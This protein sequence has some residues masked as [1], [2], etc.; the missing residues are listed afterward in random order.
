MRQYYE[1]NPK[2]IENKH[3]L[4]LH[5]GLHAATCE[6]LG[7]IWQNIKLNKT[8][9]IFNWDR[10]KFRATKWKVAA[11]DLAPALIDDMSG[12]DQDSVKL[13][14][15]RTR[16]YAWGWINRNREALLLRANEI[17]AATDGRGV[18]LNKEG[19]LIWK[20]RRDK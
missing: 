16:G 9:G 4:A 5:E 3:L 1:A 13:Y 11:V 6:A 15:A 14:P 20:P 19:K 8:T 10:V 12:S 2:A 7:F 18:L 17:A